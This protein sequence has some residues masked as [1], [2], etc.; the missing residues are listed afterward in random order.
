MMTTFSRAFCITLVCS[1]LI[2]LSGACQ[3]APTSTP[4]PN[5]DLTPPPLLYIVN[6]QLFQLQSDNTTRMVVRLGEEGEVFSAIR[7]KETILVWGKNGLQRV[8]IKSGKVEM[9]VEFDETPLFGTVV[10][11]SND[12]VVLYY[13]AL[14][15]GCSTTGIG[16]KIW[17]YQVDKNISRNIYSSDTRNILPLGLTADQK[18]FYGHPVGCAPGFEWFWLISTDSGEIKKELPTWD[19]TPR[20][21]GTGGAELSP[22]SRHLAFP[23]SS[24]VDA[25]NGVMRH[26]LSIYDLD[27]LTIERYDLPHSPSH[28]RSLLWSPDSQWLYFVLSPGT[29]FDEPSNSYGLWSLNIQTGQYLRITDFD[30]PLMRFVSISSDGQWILLQP[31]TGQKVTYVHI[32]TGEKI[33]ISLPPEGHIVP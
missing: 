3:P 19:A 25:E 24:T 1:F 11:T 9:V 7:I 5:K 8:D 26:R 17:L 30:D 22:D 18:G 12:R 28:A 27:D 29:P 10:R 31:E 23:T 15:S 4:S 2:G 20:E 33:S 14:E 13:T 16:A 21:T 32:S 6:N